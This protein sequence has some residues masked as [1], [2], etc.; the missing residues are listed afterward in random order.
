MMM[1]DLVDIAGTSARPGE[2]WG[3]RDVM[4]RG[5]GPRVGR[6]NLHG[7]IRVCGNYIYFTVAV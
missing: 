7:L 1:I 6:R 5:L 3:A 4:L 2:D